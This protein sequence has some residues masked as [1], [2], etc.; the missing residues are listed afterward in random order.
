MT[1]D[2]TQSPVPATPKSRIEAATQ[3][4]RL[5]HALL[6][7]TSDA[8]LIAELASTAR[9]LGNR[10]ESNPLRDR[11]SDYD[12]AP[13]FMHALSAE[14]G[15]GLVADGE[16]V[17][18]F[19][20]SPV[21]GRFN[22]FSMGLIVRRDG[23]QAVGSVTLERGWEGAPDRSHGG[24]VAALVDETMGCLLPILGAMAFTGELTLRYSAPCPLGVPIVFRAWSERREGRKFFLKCTGEGPGG[25]FVES[26][27][28]FITVE[29]DR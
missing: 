1:N 4:N 29:A 5:S 9:Q 3:L 24:V 21:T 25:M 23:H 6:A 26:T 2:A 20:D 17:D 7:R 16:I 13:Q 19:A 18:A 14:P 15:G 11:T 12:A 10:L 8:K 22:P 28:V 27:A